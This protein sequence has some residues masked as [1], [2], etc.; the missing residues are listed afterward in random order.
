MEVLAQSLELGTADATIVGLKGSVGT[1]A[2]P[3]PPMPPPLATLELGTAAAAAPPPPP[4]ELAVVDSEA[5]FLLL[6]VA[7]EDY[8]NIDVHYYMY[9]VK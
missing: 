6:V 4:V 7:V 8:K 1:I 9:V 3:T 2:T 5:I